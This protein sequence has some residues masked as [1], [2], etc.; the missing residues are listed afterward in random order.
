MPKSK[1]DPKPIVDIKE[2]QLEGETR[3]TGNLDE[4]AWTFGPPPPH[5]V[6]QLKVFLARDGLVQQ[7]SVDNATN[8]FYSANLECRIVSDNADYDGLP[9]FVRVTTRPYRGHTLSTLEHMLVKMGF[10]AS[11]AKRETVTDK[12]LAQMLMEAIKREP[13]IWAEV[14]W[15][16]SYSFTNAKGDTVWENPL[17]TYTDF[18]LATNEKGELIRQHQVRVMGVDRAPHDV[19]AQLQP[20]KIYS[21]DDKDMPK[22][23]SIAAKDAEMA[24]VEIA[25]SKAKSGKVNGPTVVMASPTIQPIKPTMNTSDEDLDLLMNQ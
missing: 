25:A 16:G 14:D 3:K 1:F 13:L 8:G 7:V 19:R 6:Y 15:R 21:K 9:V 22:P 4:D 2:A 24:K 10:R 18:P 20:I 11:L 23:G 17:H 5:E 12:Q